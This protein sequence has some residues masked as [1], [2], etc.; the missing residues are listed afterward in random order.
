M[1]A[2]PTPVPSR[3]SGSQDD[4]RGSLL[5]PYEDTQSSLQKSIQCC[6]GARDVERGELTGPLIAD[7]I[8]DFQAIL[9][10]P[11]SKPVVT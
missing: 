6:L 4:E 9:S 10:L 3:C 1:A 7:S 2:K 8:S 11:V 5:L